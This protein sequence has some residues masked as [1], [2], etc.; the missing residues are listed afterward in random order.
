MHVYTN[1]SVYLHLRTCYLQSFIRD[2]RLMLEYKVV[3]ADQL[4]VKTINFRPEHT[5]RPVA[6][7]ITIKVSQKQILALKVA[8]IQAHLPRV[9]VKQFAVE[10]DPVFDYKPFEHAE[11]LVYTIRVRVKDVVC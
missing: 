7:Y 6:N 4:L 10:A 8:S 2:I 5:L 9:N 3:F 1:Q 11:T